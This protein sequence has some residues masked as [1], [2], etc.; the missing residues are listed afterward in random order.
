MVPHLNQLE[1]NEKLALTS[2]HE[3]RDE[4]GAL[5][6]TRTNMRFERDRRASWAAQ[7]PHPVVDGGAD[8]PF[9]R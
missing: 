2:K 6:T 3:L 5:P 9:P 4:T 7:R 8:L 1:L